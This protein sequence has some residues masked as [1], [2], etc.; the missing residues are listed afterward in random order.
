MEQRARMHILTFPY[1]SPEP[2][3]GGRAQMRIAARSPGSAL[4]WEV[5]PAPAPDTVRFV[6][7]RLS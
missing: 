2:L 1:H 3:T 4:V 5:S 7:S 6:E